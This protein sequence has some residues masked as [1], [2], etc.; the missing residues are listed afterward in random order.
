ME[1]KLIH[2]MVYLW[3][4]VSR[5]GTLNVHEFYNVAIEMTHVDNV[6]REW[7]ILIILKMCTRKQENQM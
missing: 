4:C 6:Y 5:V 1:P 3:N 2:F 7:A